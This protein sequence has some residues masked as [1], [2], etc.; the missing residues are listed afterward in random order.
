ML[1]ASPSSEQVELDYSNQDRDDYMYRLVGA[2]L[3]NRNRNRQRN[4]AR[5]F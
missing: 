3:R 5:T 2:E 1:K 4:I